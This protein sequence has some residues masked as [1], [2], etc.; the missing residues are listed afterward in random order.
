MSNEVTP[1]DLDRRAEQMRK[2]ATEQILYARDVVNLPKY[3][4]AAISL[5]PSPIAI[6]NGSRLPNNPPPARMDDPEHLLRHAQ[7]DAYTDRQA[8]NQFHS[9]DYDPCRSR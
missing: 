3:D 9:Y 4:S 1:Q 5:R 6:A 7:L 2:R 8:V